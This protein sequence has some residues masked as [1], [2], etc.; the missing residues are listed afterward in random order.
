MGEHG[1][2]LKPKFKMGSCAKGRAVVKKEWPLNQSWASQVDARENFE[3]Q[4]SLNPW[5]LQKS[6]FPWLE[7]RPPPFPH[8]NLAWMKT[9]QSPPSRTPLG[10]SWV[11][12]PAAARIYPSGVAGLA[13]MY[14]RYQESWGESWTK[15]GNMK[16]EKEKLLIQKHS[17]V[18]WCLITLARAK[19]DYSSMLPV[20]LKGIHISI[21]VSHT[22]MCVCVYI[23]IYIT[24][25]IHLKPIY[26]WVANRIYIYG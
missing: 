1:G 19:R 16:Q 5:A 4:V 15:K 23:Y 20:A 6:P 9:L 24:N 18:P 11:F 14:S 17:S 12:L 25:A 21:C 3:P 22:H 26:R 10:K 8:P 2:R 13:N 7:D